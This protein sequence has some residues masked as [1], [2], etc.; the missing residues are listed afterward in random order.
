VPE[1]ALRRY[2]EERAGRG[3][4]IAGVVPPDRELVPGV[5]IETDL[6]TLAVHETPG[7]APSHV[8]LHEPHTGLLISGDHLLGRIALY[9]DYGHTPDPV[10][11]FLW[12]LDVVERLD[13]KLCVAGHG[14]P[15]RD[16]QAHIDGNRHEVE[17]Q[18]GRVREALARGPQ[19]PFELVRALLELSPAQEL[20]PMMVSLGLNMVLAYL[21]RLEDLGE[22]GRVEGG[23]EP[24]RW[25]LAA[26]SAAQT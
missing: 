11:E 9:F 19:T 15:F 5:E 7:H 18:I 24:E 21:R 6:G 8:A 23:A 2:Q 12:S 13:A 14:S 20:T 16:V 25:E 1:D 4:G 22:A 17:V 3:T 26:A 10:R